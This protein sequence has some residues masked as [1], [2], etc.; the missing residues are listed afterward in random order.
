MDKHGGPIWY[1]VPAILFGFFPW[2]LCGIPT[3]IDLVRRVR[4]NDAGQRAAKLL[5]SWIVGWVGAFSLASTKLPNYVLPA[6]PAL[7]IAMACFLN[8]WLTRP[9]SVHPW[10][11][12]LSFG[13]LALVGGCLLALR[14]VLSMRTSEGAPFIT[15]IGVNADLLPALKAV[16]WLG[17]A[18]VLGA[19]AC[20]ALSELGRRRAAGAALGV[21]AFAFCLTLFAHVAVQFDPLQP[22]PVL[23]EKLRELS[24]SPRPHLAQRCYF[25]PS[26]IYY[27]D[28]RVEQ[29]ETAEE[30]GEFLDR[31][32]D[33]FL[34]TTQDDYV[35]SLQHYPAGT[36][37]VARFR[38]FPHAGTILILSRP[39][40]LA[41]VTTKWTR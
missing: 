23:A 1:Y 14:P 28:N 27:A 9:A 11:P 15:S 35:A 8:R 10:W 39:D 41:R 32:D 17:W 34:I 29:F 30:A 38:E 13:S 37:I 5:A 4:G 20:L 26:L 36:R 16:G 25:R 19:A 7:A 24:P 12:R 31:Y 6:Y 22:N 40:H 2:T 33:A 21:T 3:T 18:L